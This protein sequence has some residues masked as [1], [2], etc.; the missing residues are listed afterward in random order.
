MT[1]F[2]EGNL[3]TLY[4]SD[5]RN[6]P[7]LADNSVHCVVTS[8]PYWG[9]RK[10]KGK[11]VLEGWGCAFG[12]EKS[13]GEY[14]EHTVEI[15]QEIRR[16]LRKDGVVFWNIGD[17]YASGKGSCFNPGGGTSSL[18]KVR[19]EAGAHPLNRGNISELHASGLK[20]K[21]LCLI[22]F[23]VALAAQSDGWWV[24][25]VIIWHKPNPMPESVNGWRWEKHRV[26]VGNKGRGKERWRQETG[27]QDHN[28]DGSLKQD[29]EWVDC[30]GC[31]KCL[32]NDGYVL[33]K[34]SWRPTNSYEHILMLTKS[35]NYYCDADA[36]R[37]KANY[38]GRH[39]TFMKGSGKYASGEFMVTPKVESAHARGHER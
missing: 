25:S 12:M 2:Y 16:V 1:K 4:N 23:R 22:P 26:K 11:Q 18:G 10:Y 13:P 8:P 33:L 20:P 27:Q 36:G 14:V 31:E 17:S 35:A 7:E 19:K 30:Q 28:K 15:L 37:E 9:L 29:A 6:M 38:D 24:R 39:D 32:P 34:G 3:L 5:C 21:N